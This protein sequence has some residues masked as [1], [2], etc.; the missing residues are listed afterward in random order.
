MFLAIM[1]DSYGHQP[2]LFLIKSDTGP[3]AYS[4]DDA[5]KISDL[6]ERYFAFED[7]FTYL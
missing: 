6:T 1:I 3:G 5:F 2:F 4:P 7:I